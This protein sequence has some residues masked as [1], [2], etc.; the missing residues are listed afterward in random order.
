MSRHPRHCRATAVAALLACLLPVVSAR[1]AEDVTARFSMRTMG[2]TATVTLAGADSSALAPLAARALRTF[3]RV[4]SLM[5]NW[6]TTS[7]VARLNRALADAEPY[8]ALPVGPETSKVLEA[9]LHIA[10]A[11]G[12][13]FDPTVEPLV[14]LWGFLG[15]RPT[16]PDSADI[17]ALLPRVGHRALAWDAP[18][19]VLQPA[20]AGLQIDLGGI[21]KGYAVDCVRDSLQKMGVTD[22]L[23]D[24]SGNIAQ[25]GSPPGREHWR[26]G[27]RDPANRDATLGTL[28]L[29]RAAVATSGDYEQFVAADGRR[30]GHILDPRSGW[31]A[32]SLA[33]VTVVMDSAMDADAWATA[34]CVMGPAAAKKLAAARDDMDVILVERREDGPDLIWVEASL[35]GSYSM[36]SGDGAGYRLHRF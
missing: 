17:Q 9:A 6:T 18:R 24:L 23:I 35:A 21:A 19:R 32:D 10:A 16:R 12:G 31:P 15:G 33:S 36:S 2:T 28:T 26:L 8:D 29:T 13:A 3:A 34:L 30:Y 25:L 20:R 22:A 11:S 7:D 4:D 1:A 5:S 27:L 14:R